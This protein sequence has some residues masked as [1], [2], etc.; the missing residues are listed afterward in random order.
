MWWNRRFAPWMCNRQICSNY[1]SDAIMSIW[2]AI[3]EELFKAISKYTPWWIVY[4]LSNQKL[5]SEEMP[6]LHWAVKVAKHANKQEFT[7]VASI[8]LPVPMTRCC[9]WPRQTWGKLFTKSTC[10]KQLDLI[11]LL[12][13]CLENAE[14]SWWMFLLTFSTISTFSSTWALLFFSTPQG[15]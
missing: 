10:R 14:A 9:V 11:T 5:R 12:E 2:T 3:T 7:N 6:E 8:V 15:N 4:L 1:L 13:E